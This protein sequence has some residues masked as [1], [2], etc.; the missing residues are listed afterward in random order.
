MI[1]V[2]IVEDDARFADLVEWALLRDQ[3]MRVLGKY[4]CAEDALLE[5]PKTLPD[6]IVMDIS[7]PGINGIECLQRLKQSHVPG[8]VVMLTGCEED[9][10]VFESLRAGAEGYIAKDSTLLDR[11]G[12]AVGNVTLGGGVLTSS[13]ARKVIG[14]FREPMGSTRSRDSWTR[15]GICRMD[16]KAFASNHGSFDSDVAPVF[17]Y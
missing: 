9:Q 2:S 13:I 6:V 1:K 12:E 5:I 4:R 14:Y 17:A 7:L 3:D 10:R 16:R 15:P 8:Q 11:L